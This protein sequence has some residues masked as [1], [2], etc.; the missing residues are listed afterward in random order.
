MFEI[1]VIEMEVISSKLRSKY[2]EAYSDMRARVGSINSTNQKAR[3][4][5]Y[6]SANIVIFAKY[7]QG[8][9]RITS[10]TPNAVNLLGAGKQ[11]LV[12]MNLSGFMPK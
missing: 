3:F 4:S 11:E 2:K 1:C 12:G 9:V 5:L 7:H 10:F 8:A 6:N